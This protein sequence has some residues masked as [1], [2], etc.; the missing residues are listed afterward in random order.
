[1]TPV[2]IAPAQRPPHGRTQR[3]RGTVRQERADATRELLLRTAERLFAERGLSEVSNRHIVEAAGQ[4]NNSA[5][6]YHVGTRADL[7]R[8]IADSHSGPIARRTRQ[9]LDGTR[10]TDD[11]RDHVACLVQP[12]TEHLASLGTPSWCARL[13]AQLSADPT[14][15]GGVLWDPVMAPLL[16]EATAAVWAH[17]PDLAPEVAALR[18]QTARV[19]V[20][21]TCAEQE[22]TAADTGVPADWG[23]IGEALTDTV[24]GLLL[25]PV[26]RRPGRR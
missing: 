3:R 5:L 20:V 26:R 7:L 23:L 2:D 24:T 21:H 22:R 4:A 1:M 25:A 12:Y 8:A 16:H 6:T 15:G 19:A 9:M 18:Q 11:P 10:G 13:T 17:V 14:Y